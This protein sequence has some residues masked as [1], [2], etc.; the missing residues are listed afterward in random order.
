MIEVIVDFLSPIYFIALTGSYALLQNL[1]ALGIASIWH[2]PF[3]DLQGTINIISGGYFLFL[4]LLCLVNV[5]SS[6]ALS[7]KLSLILLLLWLSPLFYI[8]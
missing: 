8:V 3:I 6:V 5:V 1:Q 2:G 7:N 4:L